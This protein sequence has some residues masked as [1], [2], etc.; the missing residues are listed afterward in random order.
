MDALQAFAALQRAQTILLEHLEENPQ[1][2]ESGGPYAA[3][4]V[5]RPSRGAVQAV[6]LPASWHLLLPPALV[7]A[8]GRNPLLPFLALRLPQVAFAAQQPA[9]SGP[10]PTAV[11]APTSEAAG[12]VQAPAAAGVA[13]ADASVAQA[14]L[15]GATCS[16]DGPGDSGQPAQLPGDPKA[17]Q[18]CSRLHS[19][20]ATP[21]SAEGGT[22]CAP[23]GSSSL[24]PGQGPMQQQAEP[25][26]AGDS[27]QPQVEQ[28]QAAGSQQPQADGPAAPLDDQGQPLVRLALL[29]PC[30]VAMRGKFP[31]VSEALPTH[32]RFPSFKGHLHILSTEQLLLIESVCNMLDLRKDG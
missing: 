3:Q 8:Y 32:R 1:A 6:E 24:S 11:R 20:A 25:G 26:H 21:I 12:V 31:L 29:V 19:P 4:G 9:G 28:S 22:P 23:A 27:Q 10:V 15:S 7:A 14:D 16:D 17:A 30:R 5:A 2:D 13:A 18:P